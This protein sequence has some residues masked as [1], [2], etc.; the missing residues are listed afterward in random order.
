MKRGKVKEGISSLQHRRFLTS[1][2][3]ALGSTLIFSMSTWNS[4]AESRKGILPLFSKHYSQE[5]GERDLVDVQVAK[6]SSFFKSP[7]ATS[8]S[9]NVGGTTNCLDISPF[10]WASMP[11]L[12][13]TL[14][15]KE[16][17]VITETLEEIEEQV[18]RKRKA[19]QRF[20]NSLD[21]KQTFGPKKTGEVKLTTNTSRQVEVRNPRDGKTVH[22]YKS[23]SECARS[24]HVNRS[25]LSRCCRSGGGL[26]GKFH[27]QVRLIC[28]VHLFYWS[29]RTKEHYGL[30]LFLLLVKH[31]S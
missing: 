24:L 4:S 18:P 15:E 20:S 26:I 28:W 19:Q 8:S 12:Q 14:L 16:N 3:K 27:Y 29:S 11:P 23:C 2:Y 1:R 13:P 17:M 22:V 30:Q 25:K 9:T 6:G 21:G 10:A 7:K 31:M 5:E